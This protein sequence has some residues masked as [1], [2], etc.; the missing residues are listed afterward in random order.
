MI[1]SRLFS[2]LLNSLDSDR[3]L[4]V[5]LIRIALVALLFAV[6]EPIALVVLQHAVL[7][8][9]VTA[10]E[11]AVT[12]NALCG[13]LAVLERASDFLGGHSTAEWQCHVQGGVGL[14][15]V[16]LECVGG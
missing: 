9:V 7:T 13:V 15:V 1:T 2:C 11:P 10:T 8:A 12:D 6:L 4:R 16:R 3:S 5:Q 14:N